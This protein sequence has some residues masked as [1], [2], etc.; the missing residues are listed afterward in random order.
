MLLMLL[1]L[2]MMMMMQ[3]QYV[4]PSPSFICYACYPKTLFFIMFRYT[5]RASRVMAR[6]V[7]EAVSAVR[8][9]V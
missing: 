3:S 4:K 5:P 9:D 1:L 2:L 7:A 8:I 6:K